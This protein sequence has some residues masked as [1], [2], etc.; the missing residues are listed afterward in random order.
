VASLEHRPDDSLFRG[1]SRDGESASTKPELVLTNAACLLLRE[2]RN[3]VTSDIDTGDAS[4]F[5]L[6]KVIVGVRFADRG[7]SPDT[8]G[9]VAT[10]SDWELETERITP[11]EFL[12]AS[13]C[14]LSY[15]RA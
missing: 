3:P 7:F 9:C 1:S 5:L 4:R 11:S 13:C 8:E 6:S 15:N 12:R 14:F 2:H 10:K